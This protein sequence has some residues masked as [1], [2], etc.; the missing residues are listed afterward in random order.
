MVRPLTLAGL[1]AVLTAAAMVVVLA[2]ARTESARALTNCSTNTAA[3]NA[4]EQNVVDLLNAYRVQN[5]VGPLKV[6]PG[7]S[8]A[9]AFMSEDMFAKGYFNHF[10]PSGR[11]PFQRAV[12]C[13]YPSTNV[14]ENLAMAGSGATAMALWKGSTMGHNENMLKSNW[15]VV[16]VG[17]AGGYWTLDLGVA[18][19]TGNPGG[20]PPPATPSTTPTRT[21]S[22]TPTLPP[23]RSGRTLIPM[24]ATE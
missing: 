1:G 20:E 11:S 22:P 2:G 15:K 4:A 23:S 24:L 21:P 8:R 10:E 18:D 17:Q 13:G 14:G 19:D 5:G 9:A 12:D 16:G 6:S 3:L 7:L